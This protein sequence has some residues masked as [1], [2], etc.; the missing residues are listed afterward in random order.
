M[1]AEE[2]TPGGETRTIVGRT[3]TGACAFHD[4]RAR[5]CAIQRN[6]GIALMP[7]ACRNFP[8]VALRDARG[9]FVALSHYCP[10]A[11]RLLLDAQRISIVEAP[12]PLS[13]DGTV[14]GLDAT[15]VMPPLLR[16][17]MLMDFEGYGEWEREAI[18]VMN[19]PAYSP[20][21]ALAAV[22]EATADAMRWR[23]GGESLAAR[24]RHAFARVRI[25]HDRDDS[26]GVLPQARKAFVA[27]HFFASW[28]AYQHRGLSAVVESAREAEAMLDRELRG[29]ESAA[30]FIAA[31][32]ATDFRLR[33]VS[34]AAG[35]E[36][37]RRS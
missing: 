21:G 19:V 11:A 16:P 3:A 7:S 27:S 29:A 8:R 4:G 10:T 24:V 13:L 9:L 35:H 17:G 5:R 2:S 37:A 23:P 26:P 6:A 36:I 15:G 30:A 1:V 28:S 32:R 20:R 22:A 14:E 12:P 31:V 18:D 25:A 34:I 33:H